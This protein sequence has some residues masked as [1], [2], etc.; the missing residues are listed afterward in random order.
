MK[1]TVTE[2]DI[3]LSPAAGFCPGVKR[4]DE[5]IKALIKNSTGKIYTLGK[6]IH[7]RIYNEELRS[8][9]VESIE[10][11]KLPEILAQDGNSETT[12][13]IRTHGITKEENERLLS[14]QEEYNGLAILDMTCP[15][16]KK[17]HNI[18]SENTDSETAF[19]LFC[20][21]NHPEAKGILSYAVG[22]K[23]PISSLEEAKALPRLKKIPILCSQTTQN[24][25]EFKEIK[26]FFKK[27]YT[28][29]KIFDTICNVTEKRQN[30]AVE[31]SK[32]ADAMLVIGGKESSNTNRLYD[33]CRIHCENTRLIESADELP[34]GSMDGVTKLGITAGA[35]TPDNIIL[36]VIK[37]WKKN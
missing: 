27:L 20:D 14:L 17:I 10:L 23:Y 15:Y 32:T 6:L 33:L 1:V 25:L 31:L 4:A 19:I 28:N 18:A 30:E 5:N 37:Q 9:G 12:L 3:V 2:M 13:V 21:K 34:N 26:N 11:S 35:S 29:L 8:M 16:V 36:E 22:A 24:L 7:N